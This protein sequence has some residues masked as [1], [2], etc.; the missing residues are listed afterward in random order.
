MPAHVGLLVDPEVPYVWIIDYQEGG[1]DWETYEGPL[2]G[3]TWPNLEIS[4]RGLRGDFLLHTEDFVAMSATLRH[5]I[6][7]IQLP[8]V[9][10]Y[11]FG[12]NVLRGH[13]KYKM[14]AEHLD[15][16]L[17]LDIAGACDIGMAVSRDRT[18]VERAVKSMANRAAGEGA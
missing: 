11:W 12:G 1:V 8:R 15:Y 10:P 14:L 6:Y 13:T 5:S 9:P 3:Q 7:L 17:E 4:A 18:V 16:Y 2:F